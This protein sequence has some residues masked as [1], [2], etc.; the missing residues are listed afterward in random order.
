MAIATT[1]LHFI[2]KEYSKNPQLFSDFDMSQIYFGTTLADIYFAKLFGDK[3]TSFGF[4]LHVG[5]FGMFFAKRLF[6][7][8]RTKKERSF[9]LGFMSH[10]I[11]DKYIHGYLFKHGLFHVGEHI[12]LEFF[13][14]AALSPE[15][16]KLTTKRLPASYFKGTLKKYYPNDYFKYKRE[17][18]VG[19]L[20]LLI[21]KFSSETIMRYTVITKYIPSI[22]EQKKFF[23]YLLKKCYRMSFKPYGYK[24]DDI[25]YP[26]QNTR[27]KH[28]ANMVKEY[29]L[30]EK[31]FHAFLKNI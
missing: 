4:K 22:P 5:S 19:I 23:D 15:K 14:A 2:N 6:A 16:N 1:H 27:K 30:A 11:L 25:V 24:I 8:A 29:R 20:K 12:V 21:Y 9:A 31:E 7:E 3:K 18:G 26:S 13:L 17:L 10:M 28:T